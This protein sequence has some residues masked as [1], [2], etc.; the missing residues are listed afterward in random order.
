MCRV[1]STPRTGGFWR[2]WASHSVL[3]T[4]PGLLKAA[5][6]RAA[7]LRAPAL[8]AVGRAERFP[9][10]LTVTARRRER[11]DRDRL[12]ILDRT[13]RLC[14][15]RRRLEHPPLFELRRSP[16]VARREPRIV[17]PGHCVGPP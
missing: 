8:R 7:F 6:P 13:P 15:I 17:G 4:R 3:T 5:G 12:P 2:F 10:R 11:R 1:P 14:A 16:R 9:R